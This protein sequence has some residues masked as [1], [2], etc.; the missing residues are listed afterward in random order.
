MAVWLSIEKYICLNFYGEKKFTI[1]IYIYFARTVCLWIHASD[2]ENSFGICSDWYPL[3]SIRFLP[4]ASISLDLDQNSQ[5]IRSSSYF[6]QFVLDWSASF[7]F[8]NPQRVQTKHLSCVQSLQNNQ[9]N[10]LWKTSK[11]LLLNQLSSNSWHSLLTHILPSSLLCH[12]NFCSMHLLSPTTDQVSA[13]V[14]AASSAAPIATWILVP[15]AQPLHDHW[16]FKQPWLLHRHL[17]W[18]TLRKP[19]LKRNHFLSSSLG[20][21]SELL[22]L[23]SGET[24]I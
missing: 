23:S 5:P 18:A 6:Y 7:H 4:F 16:Y 3:I 24:K 22:R 17:K 14:L 12:W 21:P 15:K 1:S 9:S 8:I 10:L 19:S 11:L 20:N 13:A 2:F